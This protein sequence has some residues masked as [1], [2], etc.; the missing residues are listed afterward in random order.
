MRKIVHVITNRP[1]GG[2]GAVLKNI[3]TYSSSSQFQYSF[4]FRKIIKSALLIIS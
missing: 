3:V 1:H 4:L 2:I